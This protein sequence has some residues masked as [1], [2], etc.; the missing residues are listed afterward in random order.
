MSQLTN[1]FAKLAE[2]Q[3][4]P[5]LSSCGFVKRTI[6]NYQRY[7]KPFIHCIWVQKR[8][9][10]AAVCVNLGVH[11]DF[12]ASAVEGIKMVDCIEEPD[13]RIRR[14]LA[15]NGMN[16][17]WWPLRPVEKQ[18]VSI[19]AMLSEIGFPFFETYRSFPGLF[20]SITTESIMLE[21]SIPILPNMTKKGMALLLA[22]VYE[23]IGYKEKAIAFAE[24]GLEIL[25][26]ANPIHIRPMKKAFE[27]IIR[28]Q[29]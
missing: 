6:D 12:L 20:D 5:F 14:R 9:D 17:Y 29:Q 26:Q 7:Y 25:K 13:C 11:L 18:I 21:D 3:L 23:H 10:N 4:V 27:D 22:Q 1:E 24:C 16:D 2:N 8:S 19:Q 28:R 15:P